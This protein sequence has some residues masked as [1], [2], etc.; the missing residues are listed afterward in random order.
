MI[1][2]HNQDFIDYYLSK[3]IVS[4]IPYGIQISK[5]IPIDSDIGY[6]IIG[7]SRRFFTK[8]LRTK[9][10]SKQPENSPKVS[11][12]IYSSIEK[13]DLSLQNQETLLL[14]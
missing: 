4:P 14:M 13:M 6:S 1:N 7:N 5:T 11:C 2:S 8:K 10:H 12:E 3:A 9:F